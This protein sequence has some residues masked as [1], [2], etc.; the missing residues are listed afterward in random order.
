ME[1]KIISPFSSNAYDIKWIEINTPK[2]NFVIQNEHAPMILQLSPGKKTIYEQKDGK[3]G[4]LIIE[5][6]FIHIMRDRATIIV[7]K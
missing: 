7:N 1:L 4:S 5:C 6:G 2:G 3:K